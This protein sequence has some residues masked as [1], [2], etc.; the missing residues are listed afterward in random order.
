MTIGQSPEY[1]HR[2]HK[3]TQ[4]Y[5]ESNFRTRLIKKSYKR[6]KRM[7]TPKNQDYEES[8]ENGLEPGI[9]KKE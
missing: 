8:I 9:T 3:S 4:K 6:H 1:K 7:H 5:T 2:K